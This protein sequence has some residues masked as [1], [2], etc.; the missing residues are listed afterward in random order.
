MVLIPKDGGFFEPFEALAERM[1]RSATL[2]H[3]MFSEPERLEDYAGQITELEDQAD[4]ITHD[5]IARIDRS[6]V[7]PLS[8]EDIH[9]LAKRLDNV[10][11]L[12]DGTARRARMFHLSDR[13]EP[14]RELTRVL[15]RATEWIAE[16]V[17]LLRKPLEVTRIRREIKLLAEECG[18]IHFAAVSELFE[19]KP[20]ALDVVKWTYLYDNIERAIDECEDVLH[21]LESLSL[22]HG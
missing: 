8:R 16:A 22:K 3:A 17:G 6:F 11:D 19:G 14:A 5:I 13:R 1:T 21:V 15:Q 18:A 10:V 2:L 9:L 4:G 12:M 7:T 20:D